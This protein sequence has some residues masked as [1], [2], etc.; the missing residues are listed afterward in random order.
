MINQLI[1]LTSLD[2]K[3]G[4]VP[5]PL[6]MINNLPDGHPL[7]A[8]RNSFLSN[9]YYDMVTDFINYLHDKKLSRL[10][11]AL[12]LMHGEPYLRRIFDN[13]AK[14]GASLG[15]N[16]KPLQYFQDSTFIIQLYPVFSGPFSGMKIGVESIL[17]SLLKDNSILQESLE[18]E[19]FY[20]DLFL[21]KKVDE[22]GFL[23]EEAGDT[24]SDV[25]QSLA[26]PVTAFPD[27]SAAQHEQFRVRDPVLNKFELDQIDLINRLTYSPS[28]IYGSVMSQKDRRPK[29]VS[30]VSSRRL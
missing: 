19:P 12:K 13:V 29:R 17:R 23:I 4:V 22:F 11:K 18:K 6:D 20:K 25:Y 30:K 28:N 9:N 26:T 14:A 24:S 16:S 7:D 5:G 8:L 27:S 21:V 3:S 10:V 2:V 15:S 1:K